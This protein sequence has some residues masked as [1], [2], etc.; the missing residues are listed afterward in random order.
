MQVSLWRAKQPFCSD[1]S[2]L[3]NVSVWPVREPYVALFNT[4]TSEQDA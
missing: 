3:A 4:T 1:I 2:L